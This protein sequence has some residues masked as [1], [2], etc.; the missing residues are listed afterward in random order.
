MWVG[1][2][3][4]LLLLQERVPSLVTFETEQTWPPGTPTGTSSQPLDVASYLHFV[5][6]LS[7]PGHIIFFTFAPDM[8]L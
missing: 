1:R 5:S 7:N 4:L 8:V 3:L 6:P 2:S